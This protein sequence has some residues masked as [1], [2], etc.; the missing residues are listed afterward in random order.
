MSE[1]DTKRQQVF[2]A[3][4]QEIRNAHDAFSK[5]WRHV[6]ES[7]LAEIGPTEPQR[8]YQ[9]IWQANGVAYRA[10]KGLSD[11]RDLFISELF[12]N[13]LTPLREAFLRGDPEAVDAVID[14]I[15]ILIPAFGCGCAKEEMLRHLKRMRLTDEQQ[16]R[17]RR[18]AVSL[19]RRAGPPPRTRGHG[20]VD[21]RH[22]QPRACK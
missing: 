11:R 16:I 3:L 18:F 22:R 12:E 15:E 9:Q 5:R 14:F 8:T 2:R 17:L 13:H 4:M 6:R 7:T 20:A 19:L 21:D 1:S 10:A